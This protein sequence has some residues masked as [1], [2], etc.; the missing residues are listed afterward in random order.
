MKCAGVVLPSM[1]WIHVQPPAFQ[2]LLDGRPDTNQI[3]TFEF[4]ETLALSTLDSRVV[5]M[6][7][8]SWDKLD[9]YLIDRCFCIKNA[10]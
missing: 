4:V 5:L 2:I 7:D 1:K 3:R 6:T 9:D 10:K 8:P